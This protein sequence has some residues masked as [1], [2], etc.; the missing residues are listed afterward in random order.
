LPHPFDRFRGSGLKDADADWADVLADRLDYV[1]AFNARVPYH[2]AN[3]RAADFAHRHGLPGVAASDAHS[4]IEVGV[5]YTALPGPI[6]T[7]DDLR[8]ALTAVELVTGRASFLVRGL[9]PV[10][11]VVQRL[12]GN[13]RIR[14]T[15][16]TGRA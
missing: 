4:L 8:A 10:V 12:R 14:P 2:A 9:M 16:L 1:E 11:K 7:A 3:E 6:E 5:A 15:T 13:H